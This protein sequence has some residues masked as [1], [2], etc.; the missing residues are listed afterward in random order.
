MEHL[1]PER[2]RRIDRFLVGSEGTLGLV[3]D[4]TMELVPEPVAT[5]LVVLGY[6]SMPEAAD[7][8][9]LPRL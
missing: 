5:A 3:L 1:L 6:P 9:P 8:V 4:A 2:G 7:A